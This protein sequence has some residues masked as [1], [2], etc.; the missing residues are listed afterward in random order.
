MAVD[1]IDPAGQSEVVDAQ[2]ERLLQEERPLE[3]PGLEGS[4]QV[5]LAQLL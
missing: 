3:V 4:A 1:P 2:A 5:G